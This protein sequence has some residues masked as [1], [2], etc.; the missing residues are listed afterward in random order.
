MSQCDELQHGDL[1]CGNSTT[2]GDLTFTIQTDGS[3]RVEHT[4]AWWE[5]DRQR[6]LVALVRDHA[7]RKVREAD[8]LRELDRLL[9]WL[10]ADQNRTLTV[11]PGGNLCASQLEP[12]QSARGYRRRR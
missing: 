7:A 6:A 8:L 10:R 12:G 1:G 4:G 2:V 5:I 9:D 11:S 3:I